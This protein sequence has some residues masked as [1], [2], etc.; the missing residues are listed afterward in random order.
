MKKAV[1]KDHL[2]DLKKKKRKSHRRWKSTRS[3]F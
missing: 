3:K 1:W 2:A